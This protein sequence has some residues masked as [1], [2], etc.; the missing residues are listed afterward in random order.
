MRSTLNKDMICVILV[1]TVI[2][3][4]VIGLTVELHP[5]FTTALPSIRIRGLGI[6]PHKDSAGGTK[7][8]LKCYNLPY[9]G[10]GFISHILTYWQIVWIGL[11]L[12][13]L[14]PW[15][16]LKHS[17]LDLALG[18]IGLILS[19]AMSIIAI[20]RCREDWEF[21]LIAIWKLTLSVSLGCT[22][23]HRGLIL[24]KERRETNGQDIN[25]TQPQLG[26]HLEGSRGRKRNS[27]WTLTP[28]FWGVIYALGVIIGMAG[29]CS[30]VNKNIHIHKVMEFTAIWWALSALFCFI[31][32]LCFV[33]FK[34]RFCAGGGYC[35][36][37]WLFA[38]VSVGFFEAFS[39]FYSDLVLGIVGENLVGAPSSDI[40]TLYWIY[41]VAK[42]LSL[43]SW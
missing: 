42:R 33:I 34:K 7:A 22:T 21:L 14:A 30:V 26:P 38:I 18:S 24:A 20:V 5:S 37:L 16:R 9:G 3:L 23:V 8:E 17:L 29:L 4:T 25:L 2:G 27:S 10:I 41:F 39:V 32:G 13:P 19:V 15:R 36:S 28:I 35:M 43:F 1:I 31:P 11:G 40:M 6:I 12:K